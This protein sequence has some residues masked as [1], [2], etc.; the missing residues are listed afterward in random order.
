MTATTSSRRSPGRIALVWLLGGLLGAALA[1]RALAA[2]EVAIA[3]FSS[4]ALG[5]PPA[6]WKFATLP[7]K[8]PT[9]F[10]VVELAG[11]HVLKVEADES[12]G[13]LVHGVHLQVT[14]QSVLAWRWRVDK[15]V[16]DA[17]LR[18]R[19]GD[20]SPAKVCV[21]FA[22][23]AGRLSLGERTRLA[24]A[25]SM[26]GQDVPSE[27][28]CYVWDNKLPVDTAMNN[29]FTKRIRFIVLET[30]VTHLGQW[31][32]AQRNLAAD[33]QRLFGDESD[34]KV[35]EVVGIAVSADADNT[36]GQSLAYF[37]DVTLAP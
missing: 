13:N 15:L 30:G 31:V 17:D 4:A 6:A 37:G 20:D 22:F 11:A 27:T 7:H 19:G 26:T 16:A 3:A 32:A 29:A 24:L 36:H 33:Y 10:S 34:G 18:T 2:G 8:Q 12:Y 5:E 14:P 28:L 23:D 35:P 9:R 25:Q 21:F 1:A